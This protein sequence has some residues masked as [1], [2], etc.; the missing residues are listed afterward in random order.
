MTFDQRQVQMN[1]QLAFWLVSSF[2]KDTNLIVKV[3]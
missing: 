3:S 2:T 1:L